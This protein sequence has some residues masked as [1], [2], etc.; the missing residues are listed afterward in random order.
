MHWLTK[1]ITRSAMHTVIS[2]MATVFNNHLY[3]SIAVAY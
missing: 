2:T 1:Y 3:I